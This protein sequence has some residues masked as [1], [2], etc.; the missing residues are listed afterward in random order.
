[1]CPAGR[2]RTPGQT[3]TLTSRWPVGRGWVHS[4]LRP[5]PCPAH[6]SASPWTCFLPGTGSRLGGCAASGVGLGEVVG[7]DPRAGPPAPCGQEGRGGRL[8]PPRPRQLRRCLRSG[9]AFPGPLPSPPLP[10]APW[11]ERTVR[12]GLLSLRPQRLGSEASTQGRVGQCPS[13]VL[14]GPYWVGQQVGGLTPGSEDGAGVGE[15]APGVSGEAPLEGAGP[16]GERPQSRGGRVQSGHCSERAVL[17]PPCT[18]WPRTACTCLSRPG[19]P[20]CSHRVLR[21]SSPVLGLHPRASREHVHQFR[22]SQGRAGHSSLCGAS[23]WICTHVVCE[24]PVATETKDHKLRGSSQ[25]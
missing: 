24:C 1:M 18:C 13:Q 4:S 21:C 10:V 3:G 6:H 2:W 20:P 15:R 7:R 23:L 14:P 17:L 22:A 25:H 5:R 16:A 8:P 19:G 11:G 12:V 9:R